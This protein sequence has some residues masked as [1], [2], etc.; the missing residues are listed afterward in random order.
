MS[1]RF[2]VAP[3]LSQ[4]RPKRIESL[5]IVHLVPGSSN[6]EAVD[7]FRFEFDLEALVRSVNF[8]KAP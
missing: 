7:R 5:Q 4:V 2:E 1:L 8:P 6:T 3:R